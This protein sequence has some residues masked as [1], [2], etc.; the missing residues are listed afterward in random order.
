MTKQENNVNLRLVRGLIGTLDLF[1]NHLE[2][3]HLQ[4]YYV[5]FIYLCPSKDG[6]LCGQAASWTPPPAQASE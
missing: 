1:K 5:I 2:A 4:V 6:G 3:Q